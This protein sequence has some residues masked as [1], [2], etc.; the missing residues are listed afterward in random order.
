V[1]LQHRNGHTRVHVPYTHC[2]VIGPRSDPLVVGAHCDVGDIAEMASKGVDQ[3]T[4]VEGPDFDEV[5]IRPRNQTTAGMVEQS[6]VHCI[7]VTD[8]GL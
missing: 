5:I 3:E 8:N 1:T 7:S 6:T 4:G 2:V